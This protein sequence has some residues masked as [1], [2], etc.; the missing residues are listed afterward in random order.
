MDETI[1]PVELSR[2]SGSEREGEARRMTRLD[3]AAQRLALEGVAELVERHYFDPEVAARGADE[4]RGI[5]LDAEGSTPAQL[6]ERA[7]A[8]L[9]AHDRHFGVQVGAWQS[10]RRREPVDRSGPFI[11]ARVV[12]SVGVLLVREFEDADDESMAQIARDALARVADCDAVVLDL[13]DVPGGWPTMVELLIGAFVGREPAHVL[14]FVS[15]DEPFES[16]SRPSGVAPALAEVPLFVAVDAGTASAAESCAYALQSLGRATIVGAATAGAANPGDA[17]E[18]DAGFSV[19]IST[20]S[21][22][23]PRTG[24]NW[25]GVGVVPDIAADEPLDTAITQAGQ[26]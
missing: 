13:C 26:R 9:R 15:R 8:L 24:G 7:T 5:A 4:V 2:E 21:P 3:T 10:R 11:E 20:G 6:A 25:E 19:F 12:G 23:D 1:A 22:I 18:A 16:W 14:T 17:F